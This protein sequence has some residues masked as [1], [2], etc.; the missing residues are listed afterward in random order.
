MQVGVAPPPPAP[1]P[2]PTALEEPVPAGAGA[3]RL[4]ARLFVSSARAINL[5][6]HVPP[7]PPHGVEGSGR[8]R[9]RG[10]PGQERPLRRNLCSETPLRCHNLF[11]SAAASEGSRGLFSAPQGRRERKREKES[12]YIG[13]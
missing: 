9:G 13:L 2:A 1:P 3:R 10:E 12:D 7:H 4:S 11:L 8:L 6:V 5:L